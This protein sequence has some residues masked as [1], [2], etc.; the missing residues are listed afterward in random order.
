MDGYISGARVFRDENGNNRYDLG[1]DFKTTD[2][3][4]YF[5]GLG[6]TRSKKMVVDSNNGFAIDTV[7]GFPLSFTMSSPGDYSVI[8]P[9]TTLV[10]AMEGNGFGL[11]EA[12]QAVLS[13]LGLSPDTDLATFDP[14]ASV[15][16][17]QIGIADSYKSASVKIANVLMASDNDF[18][19]N[20]VESYVATLENFANLIEQ[21][22]ITG[23]QIEFD[24]PKDISL[25]I[26]SAA[27][28]TITELAN[29]H[30]FDSY[31]EV[32]DGQLLF[33]AA[34]SGGV[35]RSNTQFGDELVSVNV[36]L[37]ISENIDPSHS[38]EA[39]LL[40]ASSGKSISSTELVASG[41]KVAI[42]RFADSDIR[43][44][45]DGS[46]DIG[47]INL[48]TGETLDVLNTFS[49]QVLAPT[50]TPAPTGPTPYFEPSEPESLVSDDG[51]VADGYIS[52]ARVF[53][54]ENENETFDAGEA[55]VLTN[56]SGEFTGLGG[57]E[58]K[59]IVAD[60]NGGTAVDTS[61][62]SV[63]NAVLSAP[64]GSKV[65]N[66]VTTIVNELMQ[67]S[68][69]G[70]TTVAE[71]N[72]KVAQV[73]GMEAVTSA[74][75]DFTK[76][77]P[78]SKKTF[79][80]DGTSTAI[81]DNNLADITQGV[82]TFVANLIVSGASEKSREAG[83]DATVLANTTKTIIGNIKDMVKTKSAASAQFD[84]SNA[85][86]IRD[87]LG[88]DLFD[89]TSTTLSTV[90][91]SFS[92]FNPK[93]YVDSNSATTGLLSQDS[94]IEKQILAQSEFGDGVLTTSESSDGSTYVV[95][96]ISGDAV[97]GT[98]T[99]RFSN[100]V[101]RYKTVS[102]SNS[103]Y[104]TV[105]LD[106]PDTSGSQD[107]ILK[108]I[109]GGS[110]G[111]VV[112]MGSASNSNEW[113]A[114]G[115]SIFSETTYFHKDIVPSI[116]FTNGGMT[117]SSGKTI[118][119]SDAGSTI[120]LSGNVTINLGNSTAPVTLN[121]IAAGLS[122]TDSDTTGRSIVLEFL[123]SDDETVFSKTTT[124]TRS[125]D[126]SSST[127]GSESFAW[128]TDIAPTTASETSSGI[129]FAELDDGSYTIR[130]TF[131]DA[132][133]ASSNDPAS[134]YTLLE[135][136]RVAPEIDATAFKNSSGQEISQINAS[137]QS[138]DLVINLTQAAASRTVAQNDLIDI[139]INDGTT[140]STQTLTQAITA[141]SA[142]ATFN[143]DQTQ[144]T[145]NYTPSGEG[146]LSAVIKPGAF[147]DSSGNGNTNGG[148]G[149]TISTGTLA[150]DF[151]APSI[152]TSNGIVITNGSNV[153]TSSNHLNTTDFDE[154]ADNIQLVVTFDEPVTSFSKD[155]VTF[156]KISNQTPLQISGDFTASSGGEIWTANLVPVSSLEGTTS[157][158]IVSN[159]YTDSKGNTGSGGSANFAID[160]R[161]PQIFSA[162]LDPTTEKSRYG[163]SELGVSDTID[164]IVTFDEALSAFTDGPR[165]ELGG[166]SDGNARY[167]T[168]TQSSV[169]GLTSVKFSYA[170]TSADRA[171]SGVDVAG[172]ISNG[173]FTG[174]NGNPVSLDLT[175]V[176]VPLDLSSKAVDGSMSGS[177]VDGY[178]EGGIIFADNDYDS[179]L[180]GADKVAQADATGG[181][182]ILG[183]VGPLI[184][185]G[186]FD[187][188]TNKDFS[189]RYSAPPGYSVIN[190]ITTLIT[191]ETNNDLSLSN[192]A[193]AETTIYSTIGAPLGSD[194]TSNPSFAITPSALSGD[195][196]LTPSGGT[197]SS[198]DV[199]KYISGASGEALLLDTSGSYR[200]ITNFADGTTEI[201]SGSWSLVDKKSGLLKSYNAY[202]AIAEA[203]EGS[204]NVT[205]VKGV[206]D[207]ALDYQ[208]VAASVALIV[209]VLSTAASSVSSETRSAADV[210]N[211]I[212]EEINNNLADLM[213][214]INSGTAQNFYP[215]DPPTLARNINDTLIATV[216]QALQDIFEP[217]VGSPPV[218]AI[219]TISANFTEIYDILATAIVGIHATSSKELTAYNDGSGISGTATD[220]TS[221]LAV[222]ENGINALTEIV[223]VQSVVQGDI[224]SE[225]VDF[226]GSVLSGATGLTP[227]QPG[228][229]GQFSRGDGLSWDATQIG[230]YIVGN[231]GVAKLSD[232]DGNY[233]IIEAFSDGAEIAS[234]QWSAS[235][236]NP[237]AVSVDRFLGV[238]SDPSNA[239][240]V[241]YVDVPVGTVVPIRYNIEEPASFSKFE[242]DADGIASEFSFVITRAG[243][244]KTTSSLEYEIFG[245]VSSEDVAGGILSG[246]LFFDVNEKQKTLT[247]SLN[248]DTL[249]EPDE[250][251]TVRIFDPTETSQIVNELASVII[252]DDDPS[253]PEISV[254]RTAY[255]A[256]EGG[257]IVIDDLNLDYF[258]RDA[259]FKL[260]TVSQN[261]SLTTTVGGSAYTEGT[262][263]D[264]FDLQTAVLRN[265]EFVASSTP[266]GTTGI[267]TLTIT[268][269]ETGNS[270][271]LGRVASENLEFTYEIHRL[272]TVDVSA[273][274]TGIA[275]S[276]FYAGV[277]QAVPGIVLTDVDS[278]FLTVTVS[279]DVE[280]EFSTTSDYTID[281]S[282]PNSVKISGS[283]VSVQDALDGLN[284]KVIDQSSSGVTLSVAVDD[285]DSLHARNTDGSL[286][287]AS[288]SA[289]SNPITVLAS[290]PTL[291][292]NFE[293]KLT[294]DV[295]PV[296]NVWG[297]FPGL[298]VKDADSSSLDIFI[299]GLSTKVDFRL[300]DP[301]NVSQA[302][303][304]VSSVLDDT[305]VLKLTGSP[306]EVSDQLKFLQLEIQDKQAGLA[307]ITVYDGDTA[308]NGYSET[309]T[310]SASDADGNFTLGGSQSWADADV[311]KIIVGNGGVAKLT[312]VDGS[313]QIIQAFSDTSAI[314]SGAWGTLNAVEL[315]YTPIDNVV[316]EPGGTIISSNINE[317]TPGTITASGFNLVDKDA[318][319]ADGETP[320]I[321]T[322]IQ[323]ISVEGGNVANI[324]TATGEPVNINVST[325]AGNGLLFTP[326]QDFNGT[327]II[328]YVVVDPE[329]GTYTSAVSEIHVPITSA[330][331]K[332][333][334]SVSTRPL[335]FEQGQ[336][337]LTI[338]ENVSVLD[339]DSSSF[340]EVTVGVTLN[341]AAGDQPLIAPTLPGVTRTISTDGSTV[342]YSG[343]ISLANI[344]TVLSNIK[345]NN[346]SDNVKDQS[347]T[348]TLSIKDI[349]SNEI[350]PNPLSS[351]T[352]TKTLNFI[353]V[354][355][356]PKLSGGS[357][358]AAFSE[359]QAGSQ[360]AGVLMSVFGSISDP[361]ADAISQI[362]VKISSGYRLGQDQLEYT[363]AASLSVGTS[364]VA[365][366][367]EFDT[368]TGLL[369]L[370]FSPG[371]DLSQA[372]ENILG[373][374]RYINSSENP[375]TADRTITIEVVDAL[376]ASRTSEPMTITVGAVNDAPEI[377][378][379][380]LD[381]E[382]STGS[383]GQ[384][385]EN[386]SAVRIA[387][388]I[389]VRDVDSRLLD[390]ATVI[391]S[392]GSLGISSSGA[393]LAS[394][395]GVSLDTSTSGR[396]LL[397]SSAGVQ[398]DHL[399][400]VLREVTI[401]GL[402]RNAG[403]ETSNQVVTISVVDLEGAQSNE[404]SATVK[405]LAAPSVQVADVTGGTG[406]YLELSS[407][408]AKVLKFN[409]TFS[410][411]ELFVNLEQ[412]SIRTE[413][414]RF[415]YDN[416]R[417]TNKL[418]DA[419]HID[420]RDMTSAS[421]F[422][423]TN[424][425]GQI[426]GDVIYGSAFSD[427][428]DGN[429]GN[430]TIITGAGDD[431]VSLRSGA[432][433]VLDGGD[434]SDTLILPSLF[435]DN[436]D[437]ATASLTN[438]SLSNF[439]N[440]DAR[441]V[442]A[443]I[444]LS[445]S[446]AANTLL[447]GS[448]DNSITLGA[449]GDTAEGGAGA[450]TFIIDMATIP[451]T[452]SLIRDLK[453]NDIIKLV[454]G[455]S[456]YSVDR[457][458]YGDSIGTSVSTDSLTDAWIANDVNLGRYF[459][460]VEH[461]DTNGVYSIKSIDIG[462]DIFGTPGKWVLPD[463]TFFLLQPQ[464]NAIPNFTS[465]DGPTTS[466]NNPLLLTEQSGVFKAQLDGTAHDKIEVSDPDNS[467][468]EID[469]LT[470][471]INVV[472]S[473][474][475]IIA[476]LTDISG[477][478]VDTASTGS[479][480][481]TGSQTQVNT[482]LAS[483][484]VAEAGNGRGQ[485]TIVVSISDNFTATA[486]QAARSFTF[487]VPNSS[488]SL[489][490][491]TLAATYSTAQEV[492]TVI[493]LHDTG[494]FSSA[495]GF[496]LLDDARDMSTNA[497][498]MR[499]SI[500]GVIPT[501]SPSSFVQ[502]VGSDVFIQHD[503]I[504]AFE[505]DWADTLA[506]LASGISFTRTTV[507]D[508]GVTIKVEDTLGGVATSSQTTFSFKPSD[509]P[510]PE[511]IFARFP[512]QT[513]ALVGQTEK[514]SGGQFNDGGMIRVFLVDAEGASIGAA[515]GDTVKL[516]ISE[517]SGQT[518]TV[519]RVLTSSPT[520][521]DRTPPFVDFNM[522]DL[523]PD[524]SPAD[525]ILTISTELIPVSAPNSKSSA[526]NV[527]FEIDRTDPQTPTVENFIEGEAYHVLNG[528]VTTVTVDTGV[529]V[530]VEPLDVS[531]VNIQSGAVLPWYDLSSTKTI[532]QG[533]SG[534]FPGEVI[535]TTAVGTGS[536]YTMSFEA[537]LSD[538]VY[539]VIARDAVLNVSPV[540][541]STFSLTSST[542]PD[543]LFIIDNILEAS[544]LGYEVK[545]TVGTAT[546][547]YPVYKHNN[548]EAASLILD[549]SSQG[550]DLPKD[551]R[552]ITVEAWGA[553][554]APD[555]ALAADISATFTRS[556]PG[557]GAWGTPSGA[558]VTLSGSNNLQPRITLDLSSAIGAGDT[559]VKVKITAEDVA[560]NSIS[561]ETLDDEIQ[562]DRNADA[563]LIGAINN[564]LV[565]TLVDTDAIIGVSRS[566]AASL[567]FS[568]SG[569]DSDVVE[570]KTH[571]MTITEF[572]SKLQ[573][574]GS[575]TL[576]SL[577][578]DTVPL[579]ISGV[580]YL[581]FDGGTV[582]LDLAAV[583]TK[584]TD[585]FNT[586]SIGSID[587][588]SGVDI[589]GILPADGSPDEL[590]VI[591]HELE[592]SAGN[593]SFRKD[594]LPLDDTTAPFMDGIRLDVEKPDVLEGLE[595]GATAENDTG[596]LGDLITSNVRPEFTFQTSEAVQ[597][598]RLIKVGSA[599]EIA[600]DL[601]LTDVAT[602]S[603]S[604]VLVEG[605]DLSDGAW[606]L[607]LTDLV[608][609]IKT[610]DVTSYG[611]NVDLRTAT[612]GIFVIDTT[613]PADAQITI[614][615]LGPTDVF[616]N[617]LEA[618]SA[619]DVSVLGA[620]DINSSA[621]LAA[622]QIAS[623]K[624]IR[625]NDVI[626]S[627]DNT[628][629]TFDGSALTDGTNVLTA[630]TEDVAGNR[631]Q[632]DYQFVKDTIAPISKALTLQANEDGAINGLEMTSFGTA[633]ALTIEGV[634]EEETIVSVEVVG[635]T[636]LVSSSE[637][638]YFVD[639][640]ALSDGEY[641]IKVVTSDPAQNLT[642]DLLPFIV[643]TQPPAAPTVKFEGDAN[644]INFWETLDGLRVLI[645][646]TESG[647]IIDE[648]SVMVNGTA[649]PKIEDHG[650][651]NV[652]QSLFNEGSPNVLSYTILD[653]FGT[654]A[655][656][657][658][659]FDVD[660]TQTSSNLF[661]VAPYAYI[662][663]ST[664]FVEFKIYVPQT[665]L[666]TYASNEFQGTTVD[667]LVDLSDTFEII[668]ASVT[669]ASALDDAVFNFTI[670]TG[671]VFMSSYSVDTLATLDEPVIKLVAKTDTDLASLTTGDTDLSVSM[672][673]INEFEV[674]TP[675]TFD[676]S[677]SDLIF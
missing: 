667:M 43:A 513:E 549:L 456:A 130:G 413:L 440:V 454:S 223:Q 241:D 666:S 473:N 471:L 24:N 400:S 15:A 548:D 569:I 429:G 553:E 394:A 542:L 469:T 541:L 176:S 587:Q 563:Q 298:E 616:L 376:G 547:N 243:S 8:T 412:S 183:A 260:E 495:S 599:P 340:A 196:V 403:E 387:S 424:I 250:T 60:G 498:S 584:V 207:Q 510:S 493:S 426:N 497:I 592:D 317:D 215:G 379:L 644:S 613:P 30:A 259:K 214:A 504:S 358:S 448:G 75:I 598:A 276:T 206:V 359:S 54:D 4:G 557:D 18:A 356:A 195:G 626:V 112:K 165:I 160:T 289:S 619:I 295:D 381:Q 90:E 571:F 554:G 19:S 397:T 526:P 278:D 2:S 357:S 145:I 167:A 416:E 341:A 141:G 372:A 247:V 68:T 350:N 199:G 92:S 352:V 634:I 374:V 588:I 124:V 326:N 465:N 280:S 507:G 500:D 595:L 46:L 164:I 389:N 169:N 600:V 234:G 575:K 5:S 331:D 279:A 494:L 532:T 143:T 61:T 346:S 421:G 378:S 446:A 568:I 64:A 418:T 246:E 269:S 67:D 337:P 643:D 256:S 455:S 388:D 519:E 53:R 481:I 286:S 267:S 444:H 134:V 23:E 255:E 480:T 285:S 490:L 138:V 293:P 431:Y 611:S 428:V 342:T 664:N 104:A 227:S 158:G 594:I 447:A 509:L 628:T 316:P 44:L 184:L 166:F 271:D 79:A 302:T 140:T 484:E 589:S 265:L 179:Q 552:S 517:T 29:S 76:F 123:N 438:I 319:E 632:T 327:A 501:V 524:N 262:F 621:A 328:D 322:E 443:G 106:A 391:T 110:I 458:L 244:I 290:P 136:D 652:D 551:I 101:V 487:E 415:T 344:N 390:G 561:I 38:F 7:T 146:D 14:F 190:P 323:I 590:F 273:L 354:N 528:Q 221:R 502:L 625:V 596:I 16:S 332:P 486:D 287:G 562:L 521:S 530:G 555:T 70:V 25:L 362:K 213:T 330:N 436:L 224:T 511:I 119:A 321:P 529:D 407:G 603:Y 533:I 137:D 539:A 503:G 180:S 87:A 442:S 641:N 171:S 121:K 122:S 63:F 583:T 669:S 467:V 642:E 464:I 232:T 40:N 647:D 516:S 663:D 248:N 252:R 335:E 386:G 534:R 258:D 565:T 515:I 311:G 450:D 670:S 304:N 314:A 662:A 126:A 536:L 566:D 315:K 22:H 659:S 668:P 33:L 156:S 427:F 186:G 41:S 491:G 318:F 73:F 602:N 274:N 32:L 212:F 639:V 100:D 472:G 13:V 226:Y 177:A 200:I 127:T 301:A 9:I 114:L 91:D 581:S 333:V 284:L 411:S 671:N 65:V 585:T 395:Y 582:H 1:E 203:S 651:F 430:D 201:A 251:L 537:A 211:D 550:T 236:V 402:T 586:T 257:T 506:S 535:P 98:A 3:L 527:S 37:S 237:M 297:S 441:S 520:A 482:A 399:E 658:S 188:S 449:G 189:V 676:L 462:P 348:F 96:P 677:T 499:I 216:S 99:I 492:G 219:S 636:G 419:Q 62:G 624:E 17:G 292:Q 401:G 159:S 544:S 339:V 238:T 205:A 303:G 209:D 414:G 270:S 296:A 393:S 623:V 417:N 657:T 291:T 496:A 470:A 52:G 476:R 404:Y 185:E 20:S 51:I 452:G 133:G 120:T 382:V 409:D 264:Y 151:D 607:E 34:N 675:Y 365:A 627:S 564:G 660:L 153:I 109:G 89:A 28:A 307:E 268:A 459:L 371:L 125:S 57:S 512:G 31:L 665:T 572:A 375:N 71:A 12:E 49:L 175:S 593:V 220:E 580:K 272:P 309:L 131:V 80:D 353:D 505:T 235:S 514:L 26:P 656:F 608:G 546:D 612:D 39:T 162:A 351:D 86:D 405:I 618:T 313:Y 181:F 222:S 336:G 115:S 174:V 606:A 6:G 58:D 97:S 10:V 631:T 294:V 45:G 343:S 182:E 474:P 117:P 173:T 392:S 437:L 615:G 312:A 425:I 192:I 366:A 349:D 263:V 83:G 355:D 48:T 230:Y 132:Y 345:F 604:A 360:Q 574:L 434:G 655:D 601:A 147:L 483:L 218:A 94:L 102:F 88:S 420:L 163:I 77:D 433:L 461:T 217:A 306:T 653:R 78:I 489:T 129:T 193:R 56:S 525:T 204:G 479:I 81:A 422:A 93:S 85:T 152:A 451:A 155:D 674:S 560:G 172:L 84:Y 649:V 488:P 108:D 305:R 254:G 170:I 377:F 610:V 654:P 245:S 475:N 107:S 518:K 103:K 435:T 556:F 646:V 645:D 310:P 59:P 299:F 157:V 485:G 363:G 139:V 576:D 661:E 478:V 228:S 239:S 605:V 617:S 118:T 406:D 149:A 168:L 368:S 288:A 559:R 579:D 72:L 198:S 361:E 523:L 370:N 445:G 338:F 36:V 432:T 531:V 194:A 308:A 242:G 144:L 609:N 233:E 463:A 231:G 380:V 178:V 545:S 540:T 577:V 477:G 66:P 630:I 202:E 672:V 629:T 116:S 300:Y 620:P 650:V 410:A 325:L 55:N 154:D 142:T 369:T 275:A 113:D 135:I 95:G 21:R 373:S 423:S 573:N 229:N 457:W 111:V 570:R 150:F 673:W 538:G 82:A 208:K 329:Q 460:N 396:L 622:D 408:A 635:E 128:S 324:A 50:D 277:T 320:I 398:R 42:F 468:S 385:I 384:F 597:S 27:S 466:P 225:I 508:I 148:S 191:E 253:K 105:E 334:V 638:G 11:S 197:W 266:S 543:G 283:S 161:L 522:V 35:L 364:T 249:R 614:A 282:L 69:S 47:L 347:R 591:I 383:G 633:L 281:T 567:S 74:G 637:L 648:G 453:S 558:Y 240:P 640:S 439:E 367:S 210:S 578:P 187:I 261:G